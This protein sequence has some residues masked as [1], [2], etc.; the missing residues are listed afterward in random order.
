MV[1]RHLAALMISVTPLVLAVVSASP[2][3]ADHDLTAPPIPYTTLR[4]S[5]ESGPFATAKS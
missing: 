3:I 5:L 2:R 1:T 4:G